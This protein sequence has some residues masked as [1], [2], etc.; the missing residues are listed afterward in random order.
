M[1]RFTAETLRIKMKIPRTLLH[2]SG[3]I[4]LALSLRV[5]PPWASHER[6]MASDREEQSCPGQKN[7]RKSTTLR[8]GVEVHCGKTVLQVIALRDDVLRVREASNGDLP[9]DASW[10]VSGDVRHQS[11]GVT[12]EVRSG[13]VGFRTK[14][15]RVRIENPGLRLSIQD[16]D[17]NILQEDPPGWPTEFH[18]NTFR[19][20]KKMA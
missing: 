1:T 15:L 9:E 12:P 13:A 5:T 10:A 2:R 7:S 4:A 20:Y 11:V 17:G 16:L 8:D 3:P 14:L 6:P 19:V 18:Q